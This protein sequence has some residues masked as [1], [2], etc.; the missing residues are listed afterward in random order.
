[1]YTAI[2]AIYE[3]GKIIL[4][5]PSPTTE[6]TRV[7]VMFIDEELNK[8]KQSKGVTIGSLAGKGYRIPDNFNEPLADLSEYM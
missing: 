3:N 4:Q 5:E 7:I 6:K 2:N 1:M 8:T